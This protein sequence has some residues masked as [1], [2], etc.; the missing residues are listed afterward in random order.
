MIALTAGILFFFAGHALRLYAP[1]WRERQIERLGEK[2]WKLLF[3]LFSLAG[4]AAL[5]WG[6]GAS[7]E[8]AE[9]WLPPPWTRHLA[10]LLTLPA[11]VLI[12]AAYTPGS[13]IRCRLGHPMLAGIGLWALAHLLANA[14]PGDLL[15]F[16]SFLVWAILAF[17]AARRRDRASGRP[18]PAGT[19]L[20]DL[21]ALGAGAL[22]WALFAVFG[23]LWLIGVR[24]LG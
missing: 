21:V 3:S 1:R 19:M 8:M 18:R 14:R 9:L 22:A 2:A 10:A 11:F 12:A 7:R 24:P 5:V 17:V 16:G 4:L 15:L 23:H 13:A 6:Y 20:G